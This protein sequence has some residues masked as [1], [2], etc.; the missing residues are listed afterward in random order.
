M[1]ARVIYKFE[2]SQYNFFKILFKRNDLMVL[3]VQLIYSKSNSRVIL[4]DSKFINLRRLTESYIHEAN[5]G[6]LFSFKIYSTGK[7]TINK[8]NRII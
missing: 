1:E 7:L 2:K 4:S 6:S 3:D 8:N 5:Q